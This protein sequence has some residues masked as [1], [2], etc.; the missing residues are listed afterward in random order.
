MSQEAKHCKCNSSFVSWRCEGFNEKCAQYEA[1]AR[2]KLAHGVGAQQ[3]HWAFKILQHLKYIFVA[4][5]CLQSAAS[6]VKSATFHC[7]SH[8]QEH[9]SVEAAGT[10]NCRSSNWSLQVRAHKSLCSSCAI[11]QLDSPDGTVLR[12]AS[13][14]CPLTAS[15][16]RALQCLL[17]PGGA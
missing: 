4:S 12:P 10:V 2:S 1:C 9:S 17:A 14:A 5:F 11:C 6:Y 13:S 8:Q 3:M 16:M 15:C 7:H